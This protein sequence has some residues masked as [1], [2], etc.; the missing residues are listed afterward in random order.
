MALEEKSKSK[1]ATTLSKDI[2]MV[3]EKGLIMKKYPTFLSKYHKLNVI[4]FF[5]KPLLDC[6]SKTKSVDN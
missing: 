6:D 3:Y 5:T 1:A 4:F 2:C